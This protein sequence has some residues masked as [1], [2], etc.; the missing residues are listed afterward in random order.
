MRIAYV[1][2]TWPP[3][4]NGVSFT[5]ERTVR[6]LRSAGHDVQLVRPRQQGEAPR[7]DEDEWRTAGW[8]LPMYPALRFGWA[9]AGAFCQRW[10][11][12]PP[13]L[14]HA[15]TP[16]P[17]AWS[18]LRAAALAH[19]PATADFRTNFHAYSRHYGCGWAEPLVLAWLRG[20]HRRTR[21]TFAPT[22]A[23]AE[24][25]RRRGFGQ[26][27][28]VGRGVDAHRFS[29]EHRDDELR[30]HWGAA[31]GDPVF[32]YVGRLAAEKNVRLACA[33]FEAVRTRVPRARLVLVGDGPERRLLEARHPHA[34][35]AGERRGAVLAA[36][37]ASADVFLFPSLTDTFGNV[38]LEAMASGLAIVAYDVAAA[39]Q[40]LV[41]GWSAC[42][43]APPRPHRFGV[44]TLRALPAAPFQSTLRR[45]ARR[46]AQ[47]LDWNTV[48]RR[49]EQQLLMAAAGARSR[50]AALA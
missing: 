17:L 21:C 34:H 35:F 36:H 27:E 20:L 25:L 42:L 40:H 28:V 13:D 26:V 5:A 16:G 24:E 15:V 29:P 32:L 1:T 22:D 2:E 46:A 39:R 30:R 33:A 18:A 11:E 31:E 23:Q 50:R 43:A 8:P 41:D 12:H 37:Y 45:R 9:A 6:H 14:V 49:F 19:V 3:E 38:V 4:I 48:L 44:A 47:A 7:D 10:H